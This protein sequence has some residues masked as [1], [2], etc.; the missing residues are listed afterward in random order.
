MTI[1]P[2]GPSLTDVADATT[3]PT[4][5]EILEQQGMGRRRFLQYCGFLATV[6][7]LPQI[8]FRDQ[9]AEALTTTPRLPVIWLNGQDCNGN[10]E[11]LIRTN[12][13]TPSELLLDNISV[14]YVELLASGAGKAAEAVKQKLI[15][16][17]G[18]LL[19]VEG[20]VPLAENGVYCTVGG[21]AF[22]DLVLEAA[23]NAIA[24]VSVGTCSSWGG[25]PAAAGGVTGAVSVATLLA[26]TGK[27]VVRLPGCPVNASTLVG[28]IVYYLTQKKLPEMNAQG[29]PFFAYG[30]SIHEDCPRKDFFEEGKFVKAWGDEGHRKGWCLYGIGCRGP[31]T[32]SQCRS[33]RFNAT[34]SDT[35]GVSYPIMSGAPC[36]S[37]VS[38]NFWDQGPFFEP[39]AGTGAS[40]ATGTGEDG[41]E[42]HDD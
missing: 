23:K 13:P 39:H 24:V 34:G 38:P 33:A 28:T 30:T 3:E 2:T 15:D 10:I 42:E 26:G 5:R 40:G 4:I 37:C 29:L 32:K 41:E 25:V 14:N 19:V 6:L 22:K 21:R 8:P 16:K 7:A 12:A 20:G 17:G 27:K 36:F 11:A 9:I 35:R 1:A 31:M 18:Y